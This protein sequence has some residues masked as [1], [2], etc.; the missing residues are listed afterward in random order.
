[1]MIMRDK[2]RIA[3]STKQKNI[4]D[5]EPIRAPKAKKV[6]ALAVG[7][8]SV[9]ILVTL[10]IIGILN[11][12]GS[13][14]S[15]SDLMDGLQDAV[16][17]HKQSNYKDASKYDELITKAS[18]LDIEEEDATCV[19]V[20]LVSYYDTNRYDDA[21]FLAEK[22]RKLYNLGQKVDSRKTEIVSLD[23][24]LKNISYFKAMEIQA[25]QEN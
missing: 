11:R 7:L 1:M 8:S 19:Y 24:I 22:L 13:K 25:G 23:N 4:T 16:R 9:A 18:E 14:L 3:T 12:T 21:F 17:M 20:K 5:K 10:I 6:M 15:C 2:E